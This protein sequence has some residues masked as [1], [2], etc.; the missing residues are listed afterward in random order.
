MGRNYD[1]ELSYDENVISI[2]KGEEVCDN[3]YDVVGIG[4]GLFTEYPMLYD[5]MNEKGLCMSGLAFTGN[6]KYGNF[7]SNAINLAP[8]EM[9]PTILGSCKSVKDFKKKY[10]RTVGLNV[11]DKKFDENTENA[12]LHWFLCDE[13]ES[14]VIES[15]KDGVVIYD[16]KF[17]VM[18]NN[19]PFDLMENAISE[20]LS[21]IGFY[22]DEIADERYFS[23]GFETEYLDGS[24]TSMGRFE[25]LVYLKDHMEEN[26]ILNPVQDSFKLLNSVEQL[27][28]LTPVGDKFEY[29][30][31]QAVY[32]MENI[33]LHTRKYDENIAYPRDD[34]FFNDCESIVWYTL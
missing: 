12:E 20:N 8:Y 5:G 17:D 4:S 28:G 21:N 24:Y 2:P 25:R 14:I 15:T 26:S 9:I 11:W 22:D 18:T 1:Y 32:D 7:N 10:S 23:R 33:S 29:T 16:N 31:Y 13:S 27:Y 34:C 19:P 6:A 30:I 3:D